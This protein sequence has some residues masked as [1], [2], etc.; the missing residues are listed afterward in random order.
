M[1][2]FKWARISLEQYKQM[3]RFQKEPYYPGDYEEYLIQQ[4]IVQ[5]KIYNK[6]AMDKRDTELKKAR[7]K[8]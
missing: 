1:N 2:E 6:R 8:G 3:R 4:G 5:W 7:L